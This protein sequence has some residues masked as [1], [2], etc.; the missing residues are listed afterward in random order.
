MGY[1]NPKLPDEIDI[2]EWLN[3]TNSEYTISGLVV[4]K[5]GERNEAVA[6]DETT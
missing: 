2:V 1:L 5:N 3:K 6:K 4:C